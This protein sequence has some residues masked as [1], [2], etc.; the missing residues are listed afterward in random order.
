MD[1]KAER[2]VEEGQPQGV[3]EELQALHDVGHGDEAEERGVSGPMCWRLRGTP[4]VPRQELRPLDADRSESESSVE[5]SD[6]PKKP[7]QTIQPL[8][9]VHGAG[10][11]CRTGKVNTFEGTTDGIWNKV[12]PMFNPFLR[13]FYCGNFII[14]NSAQN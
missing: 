4:H 7:F 8:G 1:Q 6:L 5:K 3:H 2:Q 13:E 14:G 11:D 9:T 10:L 12:S